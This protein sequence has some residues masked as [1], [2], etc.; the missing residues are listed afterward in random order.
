MKPTTASISGN[1]ST[2]SAG[3]LQQG[4]RPP[5]GHGLEGPPQVP[6]VHFRPKGV[7]VGGGGGTF[8]R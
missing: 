6:H 7:A 8:Q 2:A 1:H 3:Q 5:K 4:R